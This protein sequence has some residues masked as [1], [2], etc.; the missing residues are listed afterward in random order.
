M[1]STSSVLR[2]SKKISFSQN[3]KSRFQQQQN[4][5]QNPMARNKESKPSQNNT[6]PSITDCG[7]L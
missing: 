7:R 1:K 5:F 6:D 4:D 3:I 2:A